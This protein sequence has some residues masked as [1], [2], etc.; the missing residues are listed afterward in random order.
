M[1]KGLRNTVRAWMACAMICSTACGSTTQLTYQIRAEPERTLRSRAPSPPAAAKPALAQARRVVVDVAGGC[2]AVSEPERARCTTFETSLAHAVRATGREAIVGS[3][4]ELS[5]LELAKQ[6]GASIV[7][8]AELPTLKLSASR[9]EHDVQLVRG[10]SDS[11]A[12]LS[13]R[14]DLMRIVAQRRSHAQATLQARWVEAGQAEV[15]WQYADSAEGDA[16]IPGS[17]LATTY[18]PGQTPHHTIATSSA[19][20]SSSYRRRGGHSH[21]THDHHCNHGRRNNDKEQA[22]VA[23]GVLTLLVVGVVVAAAASAHNTSGWCAVGNLPP[24]DLARKEHLGR[25][26]DG[27]LAEHI[28]QALGPLTALPDDPS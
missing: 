9:A 23:A 14:A 27:I 4:W 26:L 19:S 2:R 6:S 18:H 12:H 25:S 11:E 24:I 8:L 3:A 10:S 16:A 22:A 15:L 21:H 5:P 13:C 17:S 1:S 28:G 20:D 7:L